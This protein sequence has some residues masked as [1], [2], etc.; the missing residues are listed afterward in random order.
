MVWTK[1][2]YWEK[3]DPRAGGS[4]GN[5]KRCWPGLPSGYR[6]LSFHL[7]VFAISHFVETKKSNLFRKSYTK[8]IVSQLLTLY[9]WYRGCLFQH[10][11]ARYAFLCSITDIICFCIDVCLTCAVTSG[12]TTIQQTSVIN[13]STIHTCPAVATKRTLLAEHLKWLKWTPDKSRSNLT[14]RIADV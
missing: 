10:G 5:S 9:G 2:M 1:S 6:C 13:Y 7:Q 11:L 4:P 12:L 8:N 14:C 3:T